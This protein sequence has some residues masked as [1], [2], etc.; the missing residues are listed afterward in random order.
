MT[1]PNIPP[2]LPSGRAL[3]YTVLVT[4]DIALCAAALACGC[5]PER[6]DDLWLHLRSYAAPT[7]PADVHA[8][9]TDAIA[10]LP[11]PST[12]REQS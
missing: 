8:I 2:H 4:A 6:L 1:D 3:A 11:E 12:T 5:P 10:T 9:F 7:S